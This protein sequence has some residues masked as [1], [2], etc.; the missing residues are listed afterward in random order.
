MIEGDD[1]AAA[2][3]KQII[4]MLDAAANAPTVFELRPFFLD[5]HPVRGPSSG[6]A[7][8][9]PQPVPYW[10]DRDAAAKVAS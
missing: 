3:T 2:R 1:R 8:L 9:V 10:N 7:A 5:T 4:T 6:S